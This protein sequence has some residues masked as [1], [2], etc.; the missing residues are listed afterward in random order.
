MG[1]IV[2]CY[3]AHLGE[4]AADVEAAATV[5]YSR[6]HRTGHRGIAADAK[7]YGG[8]AQGHPA[9]GKRADEG[10]GATQIGGAISRGGDGI[11]TTIHHQ[12]VRPGDRGVRYADC[13]AAQ[14]GLQHEVVGGT[15]CQARGGVG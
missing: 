14:V 13:G 7:A 2:A 4:A 10:E 5:G 6:V 9:T 11:D 12:H 15:I 3:T 1:D 8:S